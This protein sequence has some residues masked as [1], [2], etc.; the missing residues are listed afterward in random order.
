MRL[1]HK[2]RE[3]ATALFRSQTRDSLAVKLLLPEADKAPVLLGK[4]TGHHCA[5][6]Y[7]AWQSGSL[8]L[9]DDMFARWEIEPRA[10]SSF[11]GR[12]LENWLCQRPSRRRNVVNDTLS[13]IAELAAADYLQSLGHTVV[14]LAAWG[15]QKGDVETTEG[16]RPVY[17]EVKYLPDAPELYLLEKKARR[18][19]FAVLY[20][21]DNDDEAAL[22]YYYYRLAEASIQMGKVLGHADRARVLL[23]FG[24]DGRANHFRNSVGRITAWY[25]DS[26]SRLLGIPAGAKGLV[27]IMSKSPTEWVSLSR[28][29][30]IG[31]MSMEGYAVSNGTEFS[32][33]RIL[34]LTCGC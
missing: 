26:S 20:P 8:S 2:S 18:F 4:E 1:N 17:T 19:G 30:S 5:V 10:T 33:G 6:A 13:A 14:N 25:T 3:D 32:C 7:H 23:L 29:L 21:G 28:R 9:L 31:T 24:S 27:S 34:S 16:G 15:L 22:N 11:R 12:L